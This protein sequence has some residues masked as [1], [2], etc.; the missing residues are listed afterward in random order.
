LSFPEVANAHKRILRAARAALDRTA[1]ALAALELATRRAALA[2]LLRLGPELRIH[3]VGVIADLLYLR[4][5]MHQILLHKARLESA[6]ESVLGFH[7]LVGLLHDF[8][9]RGRGLAVSLQSIEVALMLV[10]EEVKTVHARSVRAREL[11]AYDE[12]APHDHL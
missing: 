1:R 8:P 3:V 9:W 5:D 10:D 7:I 4:V 11:G 6:A 12:A 2:A